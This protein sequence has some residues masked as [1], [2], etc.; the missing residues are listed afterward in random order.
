MVEHN[1]PVSEHI[2]NSE[3]A[4]L[5]EDEVNLC[6]TLRSGNC[7][8]SQI[9]RVILERFTK[10]ITIQKLKNI[11]SQVPD[12]LDKVDPEEF[13]EKFEGEGGEV[14]WEL[15]PDGTVKCIALSSKKMMNAFKS[16]DPPLIQLD[17]T[18]EIEAA[19]YKVLACV[20]LNPTSNKSEIAFL[21]LVCDETKPNIE[22]DLREFKR[23]WVRNDLIY[24]VD[25][26]YG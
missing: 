8:P 3:H 18:F 9:K 21:A 11:L 26:D 20:Y 7:K 17:T 2:Y 19:R 10:T 15:D 24:T 6:A 5:T 14:D 16:S 12:G 25:K 13:F 22:F 23:I 4:S 1:H